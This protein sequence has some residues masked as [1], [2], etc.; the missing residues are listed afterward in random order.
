MTNRRGSEAKWMT[1]RREGPS[2]TP[3]GPQDDTNGFGAETDQKDC[4]SLS[5]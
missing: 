1:E 4:P 5:C 2:G 3:K